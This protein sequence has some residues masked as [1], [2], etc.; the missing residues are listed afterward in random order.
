MQTCDI[1]YTPSTSK[2]MPGRRMWP[3]SKGL[4]GGVASL[5]C[6]FGPS[7]SRKLSS[8][9]AAYYDMAGTLRRH[10]DI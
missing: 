7:E 5:C 3:K 6:R 9:F 8:L 2:I 10:F 1:H 4:R